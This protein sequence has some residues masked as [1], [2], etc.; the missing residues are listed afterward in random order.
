MRFSTFNRGVDGDGVDL[1]FNSKREV[2]PNRNVRYQLEDDLDEPSAFSFT[3]NAE[4]RRALLR[5]FVREDRVPFRSRYNPIREPLSP[6]TTACVR[7]TF[8]S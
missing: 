5:E 1:V 8:E 4:Y 6:G 3:M 2:M 7:S